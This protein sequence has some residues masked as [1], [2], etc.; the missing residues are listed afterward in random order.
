MSIDEAE[1]YDLTKDHSIALLATL[2]VAAFC[3]LG[4]HCHG[5][6]LSGF[7]CRPAR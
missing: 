3:A 1:V 2:K 6:L 7:H 5:G 4:L